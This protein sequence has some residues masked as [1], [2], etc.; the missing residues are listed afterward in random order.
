VKRPRREAAS[1]KLIDHVAGPPE[2]GRPL[3]LLATTFDLDPEFFEIDFLPSL[4]RLPAWD[5]HSIKARV[6]LEAELA[7]MT[8]VAV[9]MEAR[10]YQ[11]RPRSMRVRV[12]PASAPDH[13]VLHAKVTLVVHEDTVRLVVGSA[14]LTSS[15]YR[16][17]R[18][19]ALSLV[20]DAKHVAEAALV[21]DALLGMPSV[22]SSF[23][24]G[25]A[26]K[27][28]E[29]AMA[30]LDTWAEPDDVEDDSFVW[31]GAATPLWRR[32]VDAW[33]EGEA[34]RR[35]RI[36]SPFW[37][38]EGDDG[39][40]ARVLAALRARGASTSKAAVTLV[41]AA[42]PDGTRTYRP[43]LP[44]SYASF[45]FRRLG[46]SVTAVPA[47]PTVDADDV[48]RDDVL[49]ERS[50]HAKIVI[51]EGPVTS[52]AYVGSANFT[53]PG[54]GFGKATAA[55]I[56]AGVILRRRAKAR[57][58]LE[59]LVP[60]TLAPEVALEGGGN[61]VVLA[62]PDDEDAKPWPTFLRAIELRPEAADPTRLE[63][64][65]S[66][67]ATRTP[68][69]WWIAWAEGEPP[70]LERAADAAAADAI[71]ALEPSD[72][73]HLLRAQCVRVGWPGL[74]DGDSVAFPVNVSLAA[75]VELPFGD[76]DALPREDDL[77]AFYQG[78]IAIEDVFP[79]TA[80]EGGTEVDAPAFVETGVDTSRIL[81]YQIRSFVEALPGL[82]DELLRN[83]A[84]ES[85]IRLA[86]LGPV[87]PVALAREI[88]KAAKGGRSPTAAGFQLAEL[89]ACLRRLS[90]VPVEE[91]V[92][93]PWSAALAEATAIIAGLLDELRSSRVE[94]A[95]TTAFGAYAKAVLG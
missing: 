33:P 21:R 81:S 50:L 7:R 63:L 52:L 87:S 37:S 88:H 20:A 22:L 66:I 9:L 67:D 14:N 34:V 17:N 71:V 35:I 5:D 3:A 12:S 40:L 18:E 39:P 95:P 62:P 47:K 58:A 46:V 93:T 23:W 43:V 68:A 10:R 89:L 86:L 65:V 42:S 41:T 55:N 19:V 36:V 11:G 60:P 53:V 25:D 75:R 16:E 54:W 8:S 80:G 78:R 6:Q 49:R 30:R 4:L 57:A 64:F 38:D 13:G 2:L 15:G 26:A 56:E 1:R 73:K 92:A 79:T 59:A 61:A 44:A 24:S 31:G 69:C 74:A 85:T 77:V 70:R 32:F 83:T 76:P 84:T 90:D 72:V 91:R 82:R 94:L 27:V 51:V 48:G 45:D 29:E 28:V